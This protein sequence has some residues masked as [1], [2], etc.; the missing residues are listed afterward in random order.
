MD[1][2]S[3]PFPYSGRDVRDLIAPCFSRMRSPAECIEGLQEERPY[4]E[5]LQAPCFGL[6]HLLLDRK[7]PLRANRGLVQSIAVE[8]GF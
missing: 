6:L 1:P 7:E 8:E 4:K 2:R 5:G 3:V